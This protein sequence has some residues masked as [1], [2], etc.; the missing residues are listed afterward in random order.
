M[1]IYFKGVTNI[2]KLGTSHPFALS[3]REKI[4]P[5]FVMN[6]AQPITEYFSSRYPEQSENGYNNLLSFCD[7]YS[8][9]T[10]A[11]HYS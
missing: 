4:F 6:Q 11:L 7:M 3:E 1:Q 2:N 5:V 8:R 10:F 9:G